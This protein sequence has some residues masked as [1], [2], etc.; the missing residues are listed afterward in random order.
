MG[1]GGE[2]KGLGRQAQCLWVLTWL[3]GDSLNH[4]GPAPP[5]AKQHLEGGGHGP[6]GAQDHASPTGSVW[7]GIAEGMSATGHLP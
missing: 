6:Q 5:A 3:L 7:G 4:W 1:K 2:L